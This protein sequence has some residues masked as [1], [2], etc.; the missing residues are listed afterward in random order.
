MSQRI[1]ELEEVILQYERSYSYLLGKYLELL[2]QTQM[3]RE[4]HIERHEKLHKALD[5]LVADWILKTDQRPS[6][7]SILE[8][9]QWSFQQTKDPGESE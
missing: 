2:G 6:E 1:L 7:R 8:L 5:E 3:T 4:E 9:L